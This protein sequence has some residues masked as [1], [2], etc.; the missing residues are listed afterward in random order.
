MSEQTRYTGLSDIT[1]EEYETEFF[2]S[3]VDKVNNSGGMRTMEGGVVRV[4]QITIGDVRSR[5]QAGGGSEVVQ[6][7]DHTTYVLSSGFLTGK[8]HVPHSSVVTK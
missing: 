5:I 3:V 2:Q 4:V 1:R 8:P 6:L 7:F